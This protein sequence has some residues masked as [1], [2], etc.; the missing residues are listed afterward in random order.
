[1]VTPESLA[2]PGTEHGHQCAVFCWIALNQAAYPDALKAHAIPN[3]G[4]RNPI[5]AA[6]MK[7]EGVRPGV[8]DI[9]LPVA[10]RGYHGLFI[11][12]K[13]PGGKLSDA[14]E[15]KQAEYVAD[16]YAAFMCDHWQHAVELIAWY[17]ER[18][19]S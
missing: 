7:A 13:K 1:M 2:A 6:R 16:G 17:L 9:F 8:F 10:R 3:G 14:Q 12:M 15:K 18:G 11:E 4:E 5:V 19:R